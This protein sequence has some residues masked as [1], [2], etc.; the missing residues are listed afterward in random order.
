MS[1]STRISN[2]EKKREEEASLFTRRSP[3]WLCIV[4]LSS[5][6]VLIASMIL[7]AVLMMFADVGAELSRYNALEAPVSFSFPLVA[8]QAP[9]SRRTENTPS[10]CL[11]RPGAHT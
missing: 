2:L 4:S 9:F 5:L 8:K 6:F 7:F 1:P 10:P 11:L 3:I